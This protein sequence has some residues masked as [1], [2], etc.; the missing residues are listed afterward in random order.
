MFDSELNVIVGIPALDE[1][2]TIAKIIIG[3]RKHADQVLVVDDGSKDATALI[4]E[5]LGAVVVRHERNLGYG[6]AV[7]DCFEWARKNGADV[8]VTLDG[9]GQHDPANIPA[10]VDSLRNNQADVVVGSRENRPADMS[11]FR[12]MGKGMLDHATQVKGG[13]RFVD[14]QSGF[15]AYSRKAI[16][17][18]GP[19]EQ[20]M[21]AQSEILMKAQHAGM[22]IVEVPVTHTYKGLQTSTYSPVRQGLDVIFS[23]VKF[24][25]IRHPL[26]FYGALAAV[27]LAISLIFGFMTLDY[28]QRWGRVITNLAL[29]T[30]ATGIIGFLALF[31]GIILFTIITVIRERQ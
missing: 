25:S 21:G 13:E 22:R 9:D 6:A 2:Q 16:A 3:A 28:Y 17:A 10:L 4:A 29:V 23:V 1:E 26:L 20:G 27:N 31:T 30:V 7:R 15:R 11:R 24:I 12:W 19:A 14:S 18:L 8:L 5:S